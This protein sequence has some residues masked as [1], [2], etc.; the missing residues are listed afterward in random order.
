MKKLLSLLLAL[1]MMLACVLALSACDKGDDDDDDKPKENLTVNAP[2]GSTAWSNTDI[3]FAYPSSWNEA[4]VAGVLFMAQSSLGANVNVASEP[5]NELYLTMTNDNFMSVMG[6][7]FEMVGAKVTNVNVT[8][9]QTTNGVDV[10]KATFKN[11]M[12]VQGVTAT[13]WQAQFYVNVA[14]KTY[15]VTVTGRN[16]SEML[17]AADIVEATLI[18]AK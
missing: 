4:S 17:D 14:A 15:A 3:G 11:T 13:V 7:T 12:T 1:C 6:P 5:K 8:K 16:Q 10:V 18:A 2:A 9:I